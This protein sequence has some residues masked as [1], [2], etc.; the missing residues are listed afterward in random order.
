M[1]DS[2]GDG[3]AAKGATLTT[4][5]VD[6]RD[7]AARASAE[8]KPTPNGDAYD[9]DCTVLAAAEP[10]VGVSIFAAAGGDSA[11]SAPASELPMRDRGRYEYVGEHARGGL[12]KITIARDRELNRQVAVKEMLKPT[13]PAQARFVREA[14][15]TARL[16]HPAIVPVYEAGR[17][18]SGEPFY[19]MKLVSGCS[20]AA[21]LKQEHS[22]D[23]RLALLPHILAVADAIAYAHSEQ[24]IHRDLKPSNIMGDYGE[25]VVID[26]GL[27]KDLTRPDQVVDLL[28]RPMQPSVDGLTV[29][30]SVIGTPVYMPPEQALGLPVDERAD[31]YSIGAI[32]YHLLA[33]RAPYGADSSD[34]VLEL[35]RRGELTPLKEYAPSVPDELA[36]IVTRAMS[37]D[38]RARYPSGKLLAE[39]L[40]R[41]QAGKVGA[42]NLPAADP[43]WLAQH[44][45]AAVTALLFALIASAGTTWLLMR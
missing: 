15:I 9:P 21:V 24:V 22:L 14:L 44:R 1:A 2:P 13:S 8:P 35:V 34:E 43:G 23:E 41:Y 3:S 37:E 39:A 27:A 31:V 38:M 20:L 12:G 32:L 10:A 36:A 42:E 5:T 19:S 4:E 26:W 6:T 40:R 30:G 11:T 45:V 29:P 17:W 16:E 25:T 33:G 7:R 28:A 18:P